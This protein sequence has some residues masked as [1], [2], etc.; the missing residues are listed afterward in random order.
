MEQLYGRLREPAALSITVLY[1]CSPSC[2]RTLLL[3]ALLRLDSAYVHAR[4]IALCFSLR[5]ATLPVRSNSSPVRI[6]R[7]CHYSAGS[8][9]F[10][11]KERSATLHTNQLHGV[12]VT[13]ALGGRLLTFSS[14]LMSSGRFCRYCSGG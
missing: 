12:E 14:L 3:T 11:P 2:D 7:P 13:V 10:A 6:R 8:G 4:A 1:F 5:S 9:Q